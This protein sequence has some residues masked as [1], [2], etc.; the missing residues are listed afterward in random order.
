MDTLY[1]PPGAC[2]CIQVAKESHTAE[3]QFSCN[4]VPYKIQCLEESVA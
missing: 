3:Q 4:Y 1:S 2:F